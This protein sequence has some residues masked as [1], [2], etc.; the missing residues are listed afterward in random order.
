MSFAQL[1]PGCS[2]RWEDDRPF[3]VEVLAGLAP[4]PATIARIVH[5][6]L[7]RGWRVQ[8]GKF[9]RDGAFSV[10]MVNVCEPA[11]LVGSPKIPS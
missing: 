10:A 4:E 8:L 11:D 9:R 6:L 1:F 7:R 5:L 2:V 3:E